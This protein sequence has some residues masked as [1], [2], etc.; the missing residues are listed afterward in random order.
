M[1]P[2]SV[3]QVGAIPLNPN[4]KVDRR[5]LPPPSFSAKEEKN[6][7]SRPLNYLEAEISKTA[8]EILGH[9][10]FTV[11][12]NLLRTGLT[13]L[14]CIKLAARVDDKFGVSIPVREIMKTP[15][16]LGIED[17]IVKLLISRK[18]EESAPKGRQA[19][20]PL[21]QSQMGLYYEYV[22]NPDSLMYNLPYQFKL[23]PDVDVEKLKNAIAVI[24]DAHPALRARFFTRGNEVF[25]TYAPGFE[26]ETGQT[27]DAD[28]PDIIAA[29]ARPFRLFGE[30]DEP[31][32][33]ARICKTET[34]VYLLVDFHHIIL[35]GFSLGIFIE[36]LARAYQGLPIDKETLTLF[37]AAQ[38]EKDNE[39]GEEYRAAK[40][41]FDGM[42]KNCGGATAIPCDYSGREDK[43]GAP[44]SIYVTVKKESIALG[45]IDITP[46]SLFLGA[47]CFVA[48]RFADTKNVGIAAVSSGRGSSD[49]LKT[50]GMFVKTLPIALDVDP[51]MSAA[52]YLS[53]AQ[54]VMYGA[55]AHDAYPFAKI[56]S[57]HQ[58]YPQIMFAYQGSLI[59][60]HEIDGKPL[61]PEFLA[62]AL[63]TVKFPI[64]VFVYEEEAEYRVSVEYDSS[65]FN[66]FNMRTCAECIAYA[67]GQFAANGEKTLGELSITSQA[68]IKQILEDFAGERCDVNLGKTPVALFREQAEK[69]PD[70]RAIVFGEKIFTYSETERITDKIAAYLNSKGIGK[71]G[72]VGI[73]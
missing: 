59:S 43:N 5:K 54:E 51:S 11:T 69:T 15:T 8:A 62:W 18:T 46:S 14:S 60:R 4:G 33:R 35:D 40:E 22:K 10:D 6:E 34:Q 28:M 41:F 44:A 2:A 21:S 13:S 29:F 17:A 71:G 49:L 45:S 42:M 47:V 57:E 50:I 39:G 27:S 61:V 70:N 30:L 66:E 9:E 31:L 37:D 19:Q 68:Q 26:F 67:A 48:S 32:F 65:R 25:Q 52:S 64:L 63:D 1:V 58:Y 73:L 38:M 55:M 24:V 20:S 12:T 53:R 56:A 23:E 3:T 16:L 7:S 72:A 36:E